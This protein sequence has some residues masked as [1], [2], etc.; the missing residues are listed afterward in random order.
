MNSNYKSLTEQMQRRLNPEN[1]TLKE[2]FREEVRSL[3]YQDALLFIRFAMK[4]VEPEYTSKSIEAG[5]RAKKHLEAELISV[6]YRFQGSVMTNTHI[7][8][9][10]DI[11]LLCLSSKFYNWDSYNVN[12]YLNEDSYRRKLTEGQV[13]KL[14]AERNKSSYQGDSNSDLRTIRLTSEQIMTSKYTECDIS[15]P[16]SIKIRNKDLHR[17]VDIVIAA[18]YN[19]L[20]T[21]L[22]DDDKNRGVKVYDKHV[23]STGSADFPFISIARINQRSSDTN[24]RLKKMIRFLKNIKSFSDLEIDLNSFDI[25]ALCFDIDTSNYWSASYVE[26]VPVLYKQLTR[27]VNDSA[28]ADSIVSVDEREYIFRDKPQK[29]EGIRRLLDEVSQVLSDMPKPLYS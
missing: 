23:N 13:R 24:G 18:W 22:G 25:N 12:R 10:S 8:G 16:K 26:L 3:Q 14:D 21:I 15:R 2:P 4:G 20:R 27:I 29:V 11:D 7:R 9:Y 6:D 5:N 19:D 28:H 17:D 1:L